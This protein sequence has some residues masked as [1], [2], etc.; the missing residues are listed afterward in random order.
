MMKCKHE[1]FLFSREDDTSAFWYSENIN[2]IPYEK[3]STWKKSGKD[4][5]DC[6]Y[7]FIPYWSIKKSETK[8]M[9]INFCLILF[10]LTLWKIYDSEFDA[11]S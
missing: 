11:E 5:L 4:F 10:I 8:W 6:I 7:L 3:L 2:Q 9:R 1:N